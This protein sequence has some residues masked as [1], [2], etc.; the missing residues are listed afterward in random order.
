[1]LALVTAKACVRSKQHRGVRMHTAA[2]GAGAAH[3]VPQLQ[4]AGWHHHLRREAVNFP[5]GSWKVHGEVPGSWKVHG[6]VAI[7]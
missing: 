1:M 6:E 4:G 2:G 5:P 3:L 7:F